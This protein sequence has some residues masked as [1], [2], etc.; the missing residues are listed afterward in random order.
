MFLKRVSERDFA[1]VSDRLMT[2]SGLRQVENAHETFSNGQKHLGTFESERIME[3]VHGA[4][5]LP[6]QKRNNHCSRP[7]GL[8]KTFAPSSI[9]FVQIN[10]YFDD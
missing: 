6:L 7:R 8:L 10:T 3:M 2:M 1:N 9:G 4:A 5:T